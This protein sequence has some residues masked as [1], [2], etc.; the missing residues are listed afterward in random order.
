[1][2][3]SPMLAD[4]IEI[5][6]FA[7][8][9]PQWVQGGGGNCSVKDQNK[10]WVKASGCFLEEVSVDQGYAVVDA[11]T[12]QPL[13]EE[14]GK[15]SMETPLHTLLGSFVIHTHPVLVSAYVSSYE[16]KNQFKELFPES[17]FVW[18]DYATPGKKLFEKVKATIPAAAAQNDLVLFLENHGLFVSSA[19]KKKAMDLHQEVLFRLQSF[20]GDPQK[21]PEI[22]PGKCLTPDHAVYEIGRAH[23]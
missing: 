21:L 16:A 11:K 13:D 4:L 6:R 3:S 7:G 15:A 10:M 22:D 23:V 14:Y 1:M 17:P 8:V 2:K 18:V 5:S 12:G 20:F 19:L 9:H